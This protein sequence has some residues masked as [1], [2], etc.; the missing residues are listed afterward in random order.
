MGAH[1]PC[2]VQCKVMRELCNQPLIVMRLYTVP[3]LTE[4]Y[5][6]KCVLIL[7]VVMTEA[8]VTPCLIN[9]VKRYST[10]EGEV[11]DS[12]C[13]DDQPL[14]PYLGRD[15]PIDSLIG[16]RAVLVYLLRPDS[17]NRVEF[18]GGVYDFDSGASA[19][20]P[21]SDYRAPDSNPDVIHLAYNAHASR[22]A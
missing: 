18:Y 6:K 21:L 17:A 11:C 7:A 1:S 14:G 20:A 22:D 12:R 19:E 2:R 3:I 10:R 5:R 15:I 16:S 4:T 8:R 9:R 13:D